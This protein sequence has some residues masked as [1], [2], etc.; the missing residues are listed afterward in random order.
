VLNGVETDRSQ[1][2]EVVDFSKNTN[3]PDLMDYP[4][5][6][7]SSLGIILPND[8]VPIVCGG[9]DTNKC[10]IYTSSGWNETF[11]MN[12]VRTEI[13]GM[14]KSPFQNASHKMFVLGTTNNAEV[15]T[16]SGWERVSIKTPKIFSMSCLMVLNE[17]SI[18]V[19]RGMND[20]QYQSNETYIFNSE[21][22]TWVAGPALMV[23][24]AACGCGKVLASSTSSTQLVLAIGGYT[25]NGNSQLSVE[26]LHDVKDAWKR[27]K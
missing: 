3:C 9:A 24:R 6:T 21:T 27:G 1:I 10:F 5:V 23:K 17:T 18:M 14:A 13:I 12:E 2:V 11:S 20:N 7:S 22:K 15:L 19:I 8:N 26:V 25:G 16:D 4:I